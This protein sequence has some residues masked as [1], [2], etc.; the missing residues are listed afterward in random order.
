[1]ALRRG[2]D[3]GQGQ[4]VPEA[5]SALID[6]I[7]VTPGDDL[8]DLPGVELAGQF[9]AML[10][11]AGTLPDRGGATCRDLNSGLSPGSAKRTRRGRR[12]SKHSGLPSRIRRA[13]ACRS[14]AAAASRAAA[15]A[16]GVC[17]GSAAASRVVSAPAVLARPGVPPGGAAAVGAGSGIAAAQ[18]T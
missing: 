17:A 16:V 8:D 7:I 9:M 4:D 14:I 13:A 11:A 6:T 5:A 10:R 1:M 2:I 3:A 12:P 15:V 18:G